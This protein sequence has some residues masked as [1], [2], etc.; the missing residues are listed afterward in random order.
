MVFKS[1]NPKNGK[2]MKS[3][4]YISNQQV[5]D[6]LERS[7]KIFKFMKNEGTSGI[8]TRAAMFEEVRL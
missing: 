2:L 7:F 8:E 3:V 6:K 1:I 5:Q 4:D